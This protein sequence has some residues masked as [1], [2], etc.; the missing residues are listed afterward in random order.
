MLVGVLDHDDRRIHHGANGNGDAAQAH[1][2]GIEPQHVHGGQRD[3][4]AD[5]Q[6]DDGHQRAPC[7][8][9]KHHA[10]HGHDD[11][12]LDQDPF[13]IVDRPMD[14]VGTVIDGLQR[15]TLRQTAGDFR[16]PCFSGCR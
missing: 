8:H 16:N 4:H 7:V 11:A 9:E 15:H 2:V 6:H 10:D 5:G 14:Q 3:E 1:D 12:F 13:Q